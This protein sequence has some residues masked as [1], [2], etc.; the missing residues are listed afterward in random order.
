MVTPTSSTLSTDPIPGVPPPLIVVGMHRSGTSIVSQ[1]VSGLGVQMGTNVSSH[2]ESRTFLEINKTIL[3]WCNANWDY[4]LPVR[5]LLE[6]E[7]LTQ[8][9]AGRVTELAFGP[10]GLEQHLG[11]PAERWMQSGNPNWGWKDPRST[12]TLPIWMRIF[13][14]ARVLLV[15][16]RREDVALSLAS[17]EQGRRF[18]V[19]LPHRSI[20]CDNITRAGE[21]WAEYLALWEEFSRSIPA[22]QQYAI[23][24]EVLV[25]DAPKVIG[26][27][28][29]W[30][31]IPQTDAEIRAL[32]HLVRG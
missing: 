5:H 23:H 32:S 24:Y 31:E 19:D 27:L 17:R 9:V 16:R 30:L 29:E 20:R 6:D 3:G 2:H 22:R 8:Y 26:G 28:A 25:S 12:V 4:P 14:D 18:S 1:I 10:D 11:M 13:P 21:V 7:E 15:Q